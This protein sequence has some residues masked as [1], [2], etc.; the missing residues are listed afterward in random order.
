MFKTV[1][2]SEGLLI[3]HLERN[4]IESI[5]YYADIV[6]LAIP[7]GLP[8]DNITRLRAVGPYHICL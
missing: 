4:E 1:K 6:L 3:A 8:L 7:V 2:A 5:L